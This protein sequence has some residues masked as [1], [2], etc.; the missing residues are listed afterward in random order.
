MARAGH[1]PALSLPGARCG[2]RGSR[3]R[4]RD[5]AGEA[6]LTYRGGAAL[7]WQSDYSQFYLVDSADPRFEA[8]VSITGGVQKRRWQRLS[9]GLVV[10][11]RDWLLQVIEIRIFA[12]SRAADPVEWRTGR[13]WTQTETAQAAFPSRMFAISSPSR[14]GTEH[15]GPIFRADAA[16]MAVRIQWM[17]Q[18]ER[19][20]DGAAGPA[21]V[22]RLDLW[23]A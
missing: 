3:G 9:T 7:S 18:I 20:D 21:D 23:P 12:A 2:L 6:L 14:A 19:H 8:S 13:G 5:F 15:Y 11:T 22:I 10:Y 4:I 16:E 17:E 1:D